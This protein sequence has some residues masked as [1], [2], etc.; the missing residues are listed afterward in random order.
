ML[1]RSGDRYQ[2]FLSG[3][4][5]LLAALLPYVHQVVH[6]ALVESLTTRRARDSLSTALDSER[7]RLQ[8]VQ[9]ALAEETDEKLKAQQGEQ[10]VAQKLG[11][12]SRR[13]RSPSSNGTATAYHR[14]D[15]ASETSSYSRSRLH[16]QHLPVLS[17]RPRSATTPRRCQRAWNSA[18][19]QTT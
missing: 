4:I 7:D 16:P 11:M 1:V 14:V 17:H 15:R 2:M 6:A 5:L 13:P 19:Q 3:F 18:R 12:H 10:L 8:Q 9:D